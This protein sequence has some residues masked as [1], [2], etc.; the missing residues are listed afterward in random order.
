MTFTDDFPTDATLGPLTERFDAESVLAA[1]REQMLDVTSKLAVPAEVKDRWQHARM[2]EALYHPGRYLRAA[3]AF[4]PDPS[5]TE[6]RVWPEGDVV[7]VHVPVRQPMSRRGELIRVNGTEA[8]LYRFP[9][10]RRLR[11]LR[12]FAGQDAAMA[13]WQG[14]LDAS[15]T[16]QRLAPETLQRHLLR[17]VPE[18]KWVVRLRAKPSGTHAGKVHKQRITVRAGSP[19][20]S[21]TL[22]ARYT[23]IRRYYKSVQPSSK[24]ALP[25]FHTA[26]VIGHDPA[27]GLLAVKWAHGDDLVRT[28]LARDADDVINEVVSVVRAFHQA[29]VPDLPEL[30]ASDLTRSVEEAVTDLSAT[31]P[32]L[33]ETLGAV[34]RRLRDRISQ[35]GVADEQS[36]LA[37]PVTL[38]NDLHWKQFLFDGTRITLLDLERMARGDPLID[39]AN[40]ATQVRLLGHRPEFGVDEATAAQW[41]GKLIERWQRESGA[42]IDPRRFHAYCACSTLNLARGM[43]RHLRLGWRELAETCVSLADAELTACDRTVVTP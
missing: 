40:L 1:C 6:R 3:Y 15:G 34:G 2:I 23:A 43:M 37:G 9:N 38:H 32:A 11:G 17:Y 10:D 4:V 20:I 41:A 22:Y 28:L 16:N 29:E 21:A 14:W 33:R 24:L 27:L 36:R 25:V 42:P 30:K 13:I 19:E 18:Q 8:E 12:K 39:I 7:Y 5:V 35:L 31:C 26:R